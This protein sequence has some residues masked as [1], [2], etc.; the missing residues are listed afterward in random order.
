RLAAVLYRDPA[1]ADP[2]VGFGQRAGVNEYADKHDRCRFDVAAVV[3]HAGLSE[4]AFEV[5][6]RGA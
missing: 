3:H 6:P 5:R 4:P 2:D 1:D